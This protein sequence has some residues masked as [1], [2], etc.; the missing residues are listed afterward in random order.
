VCSALNPASLLPTKG[1]P[2]IHSCEEV[3]AVCY[4]AR[5][6]L[7]DQPL[8]VPDLMLFMDGISFIREGIR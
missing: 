5:P 7:L 6:D 4:L 2:L 1:D 8:L 3:L